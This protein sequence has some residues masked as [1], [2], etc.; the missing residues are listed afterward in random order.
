MVRATSDP[1]PIA[2]RV[3]AFAFRLARAVSRPTRR[4]SRTRRSLRSLSRPPLNASIVSQT[5]WRGTDYQTS[6]VHNY[7]GRSTLDPGETAEATISFLEP[8]AYLRSVTKGDIIEMSEGCRVVG[9][10]TILAVL[11][12]VL[13]RAA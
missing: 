6:G 9:H 11:N 12:P 7:V 8:L 13:E 2:S 1:S 4:C 5:R 3:R 10:A